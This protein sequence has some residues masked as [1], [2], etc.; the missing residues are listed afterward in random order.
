MIANDIN[1]SECEL[2]VLGTPGFFFK[3]YDVSWHSSALMTLNF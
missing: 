1:H 2:F 3:K